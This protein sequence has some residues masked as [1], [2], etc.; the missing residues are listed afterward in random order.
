MFEFLQ[1]YIIMQFHITSHAQQLL[2]A[3][4]HLLKPEGV[5]SGTHRMVQEKRAENW[6]FKETGCESW[7]SNKLALILASSEAETCGVFL[8]FC[9]G[10]TCPLRVCVYFWLF[11]IYC[12]DQRSE[13]F[14][15]AKNLTSFSLSACL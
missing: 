14:Q 12:T 6:G 4:H 2:E 10:L 1:F 9:L 8:A 7:I 5:C 15:L 11:R 13:K 3:G